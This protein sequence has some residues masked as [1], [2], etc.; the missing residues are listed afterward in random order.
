[1]CGI[2]GFADFTDRIIKNEDIIEKMSLTL[3]M[4]GPDQIG[5]YVNDNVAFI[6]R[7]LSV[8]D[9]SHGLQPMEKTAFGNKFVITYNGELYNTSDLRAE[10]SCLG[11]SF[12]ENSDTEVLL[13]SYI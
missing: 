11:Y 12:A 1:M 10:L 2:G 13:T 6:H 3:S 8:I 9:L 7:R 4:R 5:N